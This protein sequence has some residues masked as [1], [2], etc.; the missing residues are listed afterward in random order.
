MIESFKRGQALVRWLALSA[1]VLGL[2]GCFSTGNRRGTGSAAYR[3][4]GY[5]PDVDEAEAGPTRYPGPQHGTNTIAI[6]DDA[7]R[8]EADDTVTILLRTAVGTIQ[9][10]DIIDARGIVNLEHVGSVVLAGLTSS[11]AEDTI[12]KAYIERKIYTTLTVTVLSRR[13]DTKVFYV[14]GEVK[15]PG[16]FELLP[17]TTLLRALTTAGGLTEYANSKKI[18]IN[19]EGSKRT[20][21]HLPR[22]L[23]NKDVDPKIEAGDTITVPHGLL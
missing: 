11:E 3:Y 5:R 23:D 16:Q 9:L 6:P 8:L 21:H 20:R 1:V 14:R 10:D 17:N 12:R 15:R 22:I 2:A 4:A 18:Y 19:R 13:L 7:A